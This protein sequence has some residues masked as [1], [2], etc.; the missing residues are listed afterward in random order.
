[1][2]FEDVKLNLGNLYSM[3]ISGFNISLISYFILDVIFDV[4]PENLF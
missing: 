2:E 4:I 3:G 1:M